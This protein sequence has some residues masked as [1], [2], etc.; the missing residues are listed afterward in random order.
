M[1]FTDLQK[2]ELA[3]PLNRAHV[4]PPAPGKYGDY[5]EG[6]RVI[7]EANRIFGFD[8]WTRQTVDMIET[9]RD[10]V[11]DK[12]QVGYRCKVR[13][14]AGGICRDGSGFGTG[15]SKQLGDAIESAVKEAET[16]ATKRALMT[17]GNPFGLALYDKT[18]SNVADLLPESVRRFTEG[19]RDASENGEVAMAEFWKAHWPSVPQEHRPH[20]LQIK[21][22]IKQAMEAVARLRAG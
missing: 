16:D 2:T 3:G 12:W 4:K 13:V 21:D 19:L 14:E 15:I 6:W 18:K 11:G 22:E 17:F 5:I 10:K 8:G 7:D 1:S 20:C 9:N